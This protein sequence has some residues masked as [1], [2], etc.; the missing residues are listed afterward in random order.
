MADFQMP[1]ALRPQ[2]ANFGLQKAG[3]QFRSPFNGTLQTYEFVAERWMVTLTTPPKGMRNAGAAEAF[4]NVMSG[5]VNR[6]YLSHPARPVPNGTLR[7]SPILQLAAARG[8]ATLTLG[9][10]EPG[11]TLEAG[12]MIGVSVATQLFQVAWDAEADDDGLMTVALVNRVRT[13]MS[14]GNAVVWA[15][16]KALFCC[17]SMRNDSTFQ[18]NYM[19]GAAIDLM[20]TWDPNAEDTSSPPSTVLLDDGVL[21]LDGSTVE[22]A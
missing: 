4:L 19:A 17:P 21:M 15:Y 7:G 5:G 13:A 18:S 2:L 1:A 6:V 9:S 14:A 22:F 3:L 11:A 20:E 8:D 10:C 16:P 12:D